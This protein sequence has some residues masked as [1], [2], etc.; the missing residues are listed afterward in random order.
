MVVFNVRPSSYLSKQLTQ[1][2]G[3]AHCCNFSMEP[4]VVV[5]SYGEIIAKIKHF[6]S[7]CDIYDIKCR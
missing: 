2:F 5:V 3:L 1:N 4:C 6:D 7:V